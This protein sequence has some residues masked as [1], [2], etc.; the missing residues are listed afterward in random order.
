MSLSLKDMCKGFSGWRFRQEDDSCVIEIPHESVYASLKRLPLG[1]Y[2]CKLNSESLFGALIGAYSVDT[3]NCPP[4]AFRTDAQFIEDGTFFNWLQRS[5][6]DVGIVEAEKELAQEIESLRKQTETERSSTVSQRRGQDVL[7]K[8][9]LRR[10]GSKCVIS[11][12][13]HEDLLVAS[14][15]KG[16][17][18]SKDDDGRERLDVENVLLLAANWDALFDKKFISFD[19]ETGKMIKAARI[20][21]ETLRKFGVPDN[22]RESISIP[23]NTDRRREYLRWHNKLMEIEDAK[24]RVKHDA[25]D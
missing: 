17:S 18:E 20:D 8:V 2:F 19:P 14:H 4:L 15:I 10:E 16:W 12:V 9:L 6:V 5:V 24:C 7:R 3:K 25:G 22:W 23:V 21:D 11:G 1:G 13:T